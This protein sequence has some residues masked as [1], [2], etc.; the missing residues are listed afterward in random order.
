MGEVMMGTA[1]P[2]TTTLASMI[3]SPPGAMWRMRPRSGPPPGRVSGHRI[4]PLG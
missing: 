1:R 3:T 2:H 4:S